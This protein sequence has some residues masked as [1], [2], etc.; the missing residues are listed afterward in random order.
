MSGLG[1]ADDQA[2]LDGVRRPDARVAVGL[3]LRADAGALRPLR[4]R[5]R[6]R[7][8]TPS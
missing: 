3:Q 7:S 1:E 5:S 6:I 8:S 2:G 4:S